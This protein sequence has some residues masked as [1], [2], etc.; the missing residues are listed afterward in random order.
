MYVKLPKGFE[1]HNKVLHLQKSE[2]G[3][4]KIILNF[5][6]HLREGLEN[7]GFTKSNHDD[8]LFTN[9]EIIVLFWVDDCI[10]YAK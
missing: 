7:R 10:F 5:Y 2:Y 9:G 3:L 8:C 6:T 1:V 4:R